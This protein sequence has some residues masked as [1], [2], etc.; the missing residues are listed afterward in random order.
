[1]E[2]KLEC[3]Q[4]VSANAVV[5]GRKLRSIEQPPIAIRQRVL[6]RLENSLADESVQLLNLPHRPVNRI[7]R[8]TSNEERRET[9]L[10]LQ[11]SRRAGWMALDLVS[12]Y[13]PNSRALFSGYAWYGQANCLEMDELFFPE[14]RLRERDILAS[15]IWKICQDCSVRSS[16]LE[17]G[18]YFEEEDGVWGGYDYAALLKIRRLRRKIVKELL[19]DYAGVSIEALNFS[20]R[21][22]EVLIKNGVRTVGRLLDVKDMKLRQLRE[23][24]SSDK[25]IFMECKREIAAL[26]LKDYSFREPAPAGSETSSRP[27]DAES[28][29]SVKF[30]Q[31]PFNGQPH[32]V[33]A[34]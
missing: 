25:S 1:M 17:T 7:S 32:R 8:P 13:V 24:G 12:D 30:R 27:G 10:Y 16:C 9:T 5:A 26:L 22:R 3:P 33:H 15:D 28:R 18:L 4:V 21:T 6:Q 31:S 11:V 34:N 20:R 23:S 2:T 29:H 19:A 14:P